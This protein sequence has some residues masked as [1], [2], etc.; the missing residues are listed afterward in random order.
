MC[1]AQN[2]DM[3]TSACFFSHG[4]TFPEE[5]NV[6]W[7]AHWTVTTHLQNMS[8]FC[9]RPIHRTGRVV[10]AVSSHAVIIQFGGIE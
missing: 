10:F 9:R 5:T 3:V 7:E 1:A 8:L 4:V 6:V 2:E